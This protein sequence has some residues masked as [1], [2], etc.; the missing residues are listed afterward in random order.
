MKLINRDKKF[1][2][3]DKILAIHIGTISTSNLLDNLSKVRHSINILLK[4]CFFKFIKIKM[5]LLIILFKNCATGFFTSKWSF[6]SGK[7]MLKLFF[8]K[9]LNFIS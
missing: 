8:S 1:N 3:F 5:Y 7:Y 6:L 4:V 2:F 9:N